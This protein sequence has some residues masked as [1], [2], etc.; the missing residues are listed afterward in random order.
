MMNIELENLI[1]QIARKVITE[2]GMQGQQESILVFVKKG[3]ALSQLIRKH[4]GGAGRVLYYDDSYEI[5]KVDRFILPC[6][7]ID[8]M[9]D[10]AMGKGGSKLM[11]SVRQVLLAGKKVEVAEFEYRQFIKTAPAALTSMYEQYAKNLIT[12]GLTDLIKPEKKESRTKYLKGG[13]V[14]EE[15]VIKAHQESIPCLEVIDS[16]CVTP[17][18]FDCA[19]E[20]SIV[21]KR[22][23]GG[24]K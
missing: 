15:D 3:R 16:C 6:L 8:Q 20:H 9:V 19:R 17:L 7:Y 23:K 11:Y 22:V 13:L 1:Q 14:T 4:V 5:E 24:P 21:I 12:Y 18:A 2:L 10:L